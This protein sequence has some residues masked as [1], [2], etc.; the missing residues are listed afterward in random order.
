MNPKSGFMLYLMANSKMRVAVAGTNTLAL[1]ISHA[2]VTETSH[3]LV[4]LSRQAQPNLTSQGYQVLVVDYN[5][6]NSIQHAVTG[7][8]TV[9]STVTGL[10]ELRLLEACVAQRVR[11]FAPAE[12]EGRPSARPSNDPLDRGKKTILDWLDYYKS[13][14]DLESTVF[15]CGVLY[16]RFGPG[17]LAAHR[18]GLNTSLCNEG[19]YIINCRT[20]EANAPVYNANNQANVYVCMIGVQ[21]AARFIT[22]ALD[23]ARWPRE[24]TMAAERMT[25]NEIIDTVVRVRGTPLTSETWHSPATLRHELQLAEMFNDIPRQMRAHDHLATINGRYVFS[26]PGNLRNSAI[27]RDIVPVRFE[28]WLRSVWAGHVHVT[29]P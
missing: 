22:R 23:L 18:L 5:D 11:R 15:V 24:M 19:D 3:S 10:P 4:I 14:V 16:E 21:D 6:Q 13:S 8:D 7:V 26:A 20:M 9:I 12:F 2:I 27:T 1:M 25:V 28:T 17:G 29:E